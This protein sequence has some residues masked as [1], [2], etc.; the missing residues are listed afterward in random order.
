MGRTCKKELVVIN[1]SEIWKVKQELGSEKRYEI[2]D[3][4]VVR[5]VTKTELNRRKTECQ[6]ELSRLQ[7]EIKSINA[8]L[9]KIV[10]LEKV[11]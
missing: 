8:D 4:V 5:T 1:M 3:T 10:N 9:I 6:E 7:N 2:K 11:K